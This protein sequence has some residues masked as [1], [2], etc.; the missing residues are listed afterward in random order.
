MSPG[1]Y[2]ITLTANNAINN[3]KFLTYAITHV[4]TFQITRR[5][6]ER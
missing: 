5:S 6:V 3:R 1:V 2:L 4:N